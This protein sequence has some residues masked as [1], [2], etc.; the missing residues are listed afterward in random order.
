MKLKLIFITILFSVYFKLSAQQ[1]YFTVS[2]YVK[3]SKDSSA[4]NLANITIKG[5]PIGTFSNEIGEF[6]FHIPD[7]LN[8][9]ELVISAIGYYNLSLKAENINSSQIFLLRPHDYEIKEIIVFPDSMEAKYIV[10]KAIRKIPK[11]YSKKKFFIEA[12]YRGLAYNNTSYLRLVEAA[13]GVF[14]FGYDSNNMR[15][16]I[17][18]IELRK[19]IDYV[20]YS[21]YR[22]VFEFMY[23]NKNILYDVYYSDPLRS[24][25]EKHITINNNFI[26]VFKLHLVDI[27]YLNDKL[28]YVISFNKTRYDGNDGINGQL[29]INVHDYAFVKLIAGWYTMSPKGHRLRKLLYK[30]NYWYQNI[31]TFKKYNGRYYPNYIEHNS[32][33]EDFSD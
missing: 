6:T 32:V 22:K 30:E 18:I 12:F 14:D 3:S 31:I 29:F 13:I 26:K 23:G 24:S 7:S 25:D 5:Q 20:K 11:N 1:N 10:K 16:R 4:I 9:Q 19:S 28:V 2:G 17:K 27:T 8:N 15:S 33:L 21:L